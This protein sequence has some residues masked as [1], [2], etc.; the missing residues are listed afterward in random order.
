MK[1]IDVPEWS[2]CDKR[3]GQLNSSDR[4]IAQ[5]VISGDGLTPLESV[6]HAYDDSCPK[7]SEVFISDIKNLVEWCLNNPGQVLAKHEQLT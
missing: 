1:S 5:S 3:L 2:E 7:R 6:I 4:T